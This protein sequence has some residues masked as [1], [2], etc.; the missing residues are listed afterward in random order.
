M[1][2]AL[3]REGILVRVVLYY[4]WVK[5]ILITISTHSSDVYCLHMPKV[6][7]RARNDCNALSRVGMS[8]DMK[9]PTMW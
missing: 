6:L 8:R 2:Y 3:N 7:C 1:I 9:V 5:C 4:N